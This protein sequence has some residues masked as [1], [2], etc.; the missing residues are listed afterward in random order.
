M[1]KTLLVVGGT[2]EKKW[3]LLGAIAT[4]AEQRG[5]TPE[6]VNYP[7]S[8]GNPQSFE[9]SLGDGVRAFGMELA[10]AVGRS[11]VVAA[12]G[13]SQGA[14]VVEKALREKAADMAP[15]GID[16][17]LL[18]KVR[19]VGLFGNPYRA[20][21][22]QVGPNPGGYGVVGPLAPASARPPIAGR[23][24][25]YA[26]P[27]D[28]ISSCPADSLVRFIYPFTRWMSVQ[29]VDRWAGDVLSKLSLW[30]LLR[31]VPELRDVRQI[32]N[33]LLRIQRATEQVY[34]YQTTGI[35]GQYAG[36]ALGGGFGV[37]T[38]LAL[39]ALEEL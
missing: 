12:V 11:D 13:F 1:K 15:L 17:L 34:H 7:A 39:N 37:P 35:H 33:L 4:R 38:Q 3:G 31:N 29:D 28:L 18:S 27:G 2:W 23:W 32:P 30:W 6:W 10:E 36:R 14:A 21:G 9:R 24:E 20:P 26:L 22:D 8:Y 25:N 19:Y 16:R 5:W